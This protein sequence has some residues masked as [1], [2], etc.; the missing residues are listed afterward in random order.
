MRVFR[1]Q[2][3]RLAHFLDGS[4][5]QLGEWVVIKSDL[6]REYGFE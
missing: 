3:Q 5:T 4:S 1:D 2:A 6:D